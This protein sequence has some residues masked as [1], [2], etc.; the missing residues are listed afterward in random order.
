MSKTDMT[1]GAEVWAWNSTFCSLVSKDSLGYDFTLY[2]SQALSV[3]NNELYAVVSSNI[4]KLRV[5]K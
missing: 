3:Y 5:Y 4:G 1:S 2:S